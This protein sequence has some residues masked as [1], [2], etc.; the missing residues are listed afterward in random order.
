MQRV[1]S[2]ARRESGK[3]YDT[4]DLDRIPDCDFE[5]ETVLLFYNSMLDL[6][7]REWKVIEEQTNEPTVAEVEMKYFKDVTQD[8]LT[9]STVLVAEGSKVS[10]SKK[11]RGKFSKIKKRRSDGSQGSLITGAPVKSES[12]KSS[13]SEEVVE[14]IIKL[15]ASAASPFGSNYAV[16][17]TNNNSKRNITDWFVTAGREYVRITFMN[18]NVFEG[19]VDNKQ[20][21][22]NGT[23]TWSNGTVYEGEFRKGDITGRGKQFYKDNSTYS[24]TFCKGVLNGTGSIY[25]AS[26][27]ILYSGDWKRGKQNGKGWILYEPQNWYDG[28]WLNGIRHGKGLR[29]YNNSCRYQGNWLNGNRHGQG[30]MVWSNNDF[31]SGEWKN[32]VMDGYGEY[33]WKA[34]YNNEFIFPLLNS[35]E[36]QWINGMRSGVGVLHFGFTGGARMAGEWVRNMKHGAGLIVCGNGKTIKGNLLFM[37]DKPV[38]MQLFRNN[39]ATLSKPS[40]NRRN[41]VEPIE[42][43]PTVLAPDTF[44]PDNDED[45][46]R[47]NIFSEI[48]LTYS[49]QVNPLRIPVHSEPNAVDLTYY[50]KKVCSKYGFEY[51]DLHSPPSKEISYEEGNARTQIIN[52]EEKKLRFSITYHYLLIQTAYN[53]YAKISSKRTIFFR[54]ILVR[55]FLWQLYLDAGVS[56]AM[57]L[58]DTDLCLLDNPD[59]GL[60]SEHNPFEKIYFWQFIYSLLS[61][62]WALYSNKCDDEKANGILAAVFTKLLRENIEPNIGNFKGGAL[63]EYVNILPMENVYL[64]YRGVGE[65]HTVRKFICDCLSKFRGICEDIFGKDKVTH[66]K[67]GANMVIGRIIYVP[68][69]IGIGES[70]TEPTAYPFNGRVS[71]SLRLFKELKPKVLMKC[72]GQECPMVMENDLIINMDYKLSFLEFYNILISATKKMIDIAKKEEQNI[73]A[74]TE[75]LLA[76]DSKSGRKPSIGKKRRNVL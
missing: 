63:F 25:I 46:D 1:V 27:N 18:G 31:Y 65:P 34:F 17:R 40:L 76:K 71:E 41:T 8:D 21:D 57:S 44:C 43:D 55:L 16:Q 60:E 59:C 30:T 49:S 12:R 33:V 73:K 69:D 14:Q 32:G 38:D 51:C 64:L 35:Y 62:A 50:L 26:S 29:Q 74:Q 66:I 7:V 24:G 54:A 45:L 6:I 9:G 36:G 22:G 56:K 11:G 15:T 72:I 58:I 37:Y 23:F 28:E 13:A 70:P 67:K 68:N 2:F 20:F 53:T 48:P 61:V 42:K 4:I 10:F 52:F 3:S 39:R 19:F 47:M 5:K 75:L